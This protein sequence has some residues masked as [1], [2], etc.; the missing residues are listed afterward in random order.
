MT[1]TSPMS[2]IAERLLLGG[3]C[4]LTAVGGFVNGASSAAALVGP[5]DRDTRHTSVGV[6]LPDPAM[7]VPKTC[8]ATLV[9]PRVVVVA[10]HC[11]AIR[12]Q[13][14]GLT[15]GTVSFDDDLTDG[16]QGPTYDGDLVLDP[17]Y[18][19]N[20]AARDLGAVVLD[21]PVTGVDPV[22]LPDAGTLSAAKAAGA[23][24]RVR[25]VAYGTTQRRPG[26][27]LDGA[28]ARRTSLNEVQGLTQGVLKSRATG[29]QAS[30]CDLDSGGAVLFGGEVVA[31]VSRADAACSTAT[32]STR[33]DR[34]EVLTW[35]SGL[36]ADV[37]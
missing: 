7:P 29:D 19:P 2:S 26:N 15:R 18:T 34:G 9:S 31:V 32:G 4:L 25:L 30:A 12:R 27:V 22:P 23:L 3:I 33:L 21:E 14:F 13:A 1:T 35:L 24:D 36:A 17:A 20:S 8:G 6:L 10:G 5:S 28:G 37:G 16:V 11:V